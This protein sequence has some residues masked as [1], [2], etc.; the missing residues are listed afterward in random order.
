MR[1]TAGQGSGR[2]PEAKYVFQLL[3]KAWFSPVTLKY[4][5]SHSG[6][7]TFYIKWKRVNIFDPY[8]YVYAYASYAYPFAYVYAYPSYAYPCVYAYANYAY[9]C[10]YAYASYAYPYAYVYAYPS[11]VRLRK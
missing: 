6:K 3:I 10:V 11:Y 4:K 9:P 5:H 2:V 8:A 1:L 7:I